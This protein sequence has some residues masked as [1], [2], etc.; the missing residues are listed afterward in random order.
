MG[1]L[2]RKKCAHSMWVPRSTGMTNKISKLL[3]LLVVASI[4]TG[5]VVRSTPART[6]TVVRHR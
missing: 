5:C 2:H 6:V 1:F 3:A 4:A